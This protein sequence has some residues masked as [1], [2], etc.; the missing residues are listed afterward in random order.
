MN[1]ELENIKDRYKKMIDDVY[2]VDDMWD[3]IQDRLQIRL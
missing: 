2:C 1:N 3:V